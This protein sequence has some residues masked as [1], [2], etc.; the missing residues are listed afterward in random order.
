[1]ANPIISLSKVNKF[2]GN[3]SV[4]QQVLYDIN[5]EIENGEFISIVGTSGSGKTTL[6][7]IIGGLDRRYE[8]SCVVAGNKIEKLGEKSL[9]KMR[10]RDLGF[11]FQSF[12]LME[13]LTAWENVALSSYFA[14]TKIPYGE[15]FAR[16]KEVLEKVGLHEKIKAYPANLSGGQKQRVAI[17]RAL[18]NS[19]KIL[20]CDE[21]TGNLDS[22]T[23]REVIELFK[24]LNREDKITL[25][26]ITHEDRV[27]K[28][29][30]RSI[31]LEDG[32]VVSFAKDQSPVH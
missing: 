16:A 18:F 10:N 32:K 30:D 28:T 4:K 12:A 7:N 1:M 5:L 23:G 22:N 19:P 29:T 17:A 6:L 9:A 11:I 21:P 8:G 26:V 14:G 3:G 15:E 27:S 24:K 2:Y 25:L 31:Q 13:H 20:L